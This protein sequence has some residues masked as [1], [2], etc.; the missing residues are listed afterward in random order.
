[1]SKDRSIFA[2]SRDPAQT[3][4]IGCCVRDESHG[5]L[6]NAGAPYIT[7]PNRFVNEASGERWLA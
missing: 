4:T 2:M 1:M 7:M 5:R 3:P 6:A